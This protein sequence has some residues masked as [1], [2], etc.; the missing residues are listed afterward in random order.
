M[1]VFIIGTPFETAESLDKKRLNKQ[2][3]ECKQILK[4]I[5]GESKAWKNHPCTKQ[6]EKHKIW[7]CY[8]L[9]SLGYYKEGNKEASIRYSNYA[10]F[11]RPNFHTKDYFNQMKRRLYTKD[12]SFYNQWNFLGESNINWYYD[13]NENKFIYYENGKKIKNIS[14]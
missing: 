12:K 5:D 6:Y 8:Y 14:I 1:Q 13:N 4:A 10:N 3:I 2:I 11:Y 7:L 9:M